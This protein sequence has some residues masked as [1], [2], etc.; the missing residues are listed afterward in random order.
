MCLIPI[1]V[2]LN[3]KYIIGL[4]RFQAFCRINLFNGIASCHQLV[5]IAKSQLAIGIRNF[6]V[7]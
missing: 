7:K 1:T 5:R 2:L 6:R 3:N 4:D